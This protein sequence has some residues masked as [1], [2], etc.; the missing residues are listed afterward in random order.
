MNEGSA[1]S[2]SVWEGQGVKLHSLRFSGYAKQV[3][4]V[5]RVDQE[6]KNYYKEDDPTAIWW[7]F[8]SNILC[9][10]SRSVRKNQELFPTL[11]HLSG[12]GGMLTDL[13]MLNTPKSPR[14]RPEMSAA[15]EHSTPNPTPI[16]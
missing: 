12:D 15:I 8:S 16:K 1:D 9:I 14:Q 6:T 4:T 3:H 5:L 10:T 13:R 11:S 2:I 7:A